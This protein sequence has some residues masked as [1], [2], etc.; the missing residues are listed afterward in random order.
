ME[1]R[2]APPASA[3]VAVR[4]VAGS[5]ATCHHCCTS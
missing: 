2:D 1:A 5:C 4:L 3:H